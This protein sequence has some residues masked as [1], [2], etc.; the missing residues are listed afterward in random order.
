MGAFPKKNL[1]PKTCKK[2]WRDFRQLLTLTT[3]ISETDE[4]IQNRTITRSTVVSFTFRKKSCELCSTIIPD[5]KA[6][7]YPQSHINQLFWKTIF[8]PLRGTCLR[9]Q[10]SVFTRTKEWPR[11]ASTHLTVDGGPPRFFYKRRV[12]NWLRMQRMHAYSFGGKGSNPVKLCSVTCREVGM[13]TKQILEDKHPKNLG[14]QKRAK[15]GAF[16][17]NFRL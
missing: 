1:G 15:I 17:G 7:S 12:K 11:L 5:L 14:S 8:R 3:N 13:T 2:I 10:H 6:E 16:S 4:D 9:V